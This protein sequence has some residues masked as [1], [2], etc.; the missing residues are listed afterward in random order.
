MNMETLICLKS[1]A[2][3]SLNQPTHFSAVKMQLRK[4]A[5]EVQHTLYKSLHANLAQE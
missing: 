3:P 5:D 1:Q 2:I 4:H